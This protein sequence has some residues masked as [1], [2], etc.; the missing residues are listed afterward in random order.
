VQPDVITDQ[1]RSLGRIMIALSLAVPFLLLIG[2]AKRSYFV[3]AI[4]VLLVVTIVSG[5]S[6]WAGCTMANPISDESDSYES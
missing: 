2:I 1:S 5:V 6:L 3:V 4:P